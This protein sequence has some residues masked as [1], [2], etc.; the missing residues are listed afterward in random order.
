MPEQDKEEKSERAQMVRVTEALC[1]IDY[2]TVDELNARIAFIKG[3][4]VRFRLKEF[5]TV[6]IEG[7]VKEAPPRPQP[8][9]RR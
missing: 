9:S 3:L 5:R 2:P 8:G 1:S 7:P 6:A 4:G